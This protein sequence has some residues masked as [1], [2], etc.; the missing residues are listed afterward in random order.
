MTEE[1]FELSPCKEKGLL[2][3]HHNIWRYEKKQEVKKKTVA[4]SLEPGLAVEVYPPDLGAAPGRGL[5]LVQRGGVRGGP[6]P[7]FLKAPSEP[8]LCFCRPFFLFRLSHHFSMF[9]RQLLSN[10]DTIRFHNNYLYNR[11]DLCV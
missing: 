2:F 6:T 10:D 5:R 9:S 4:Q 1:F 11:D 8:V 7:T 3:L